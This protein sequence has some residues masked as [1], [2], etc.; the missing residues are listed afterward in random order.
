MLPSTTQSDKILNGISIPSTSSCN[1]CSIIHFKQKLLP[2][3]S[4]GR[5]SGTNELFLY[6]MW[7]LWRVTNVVYVGVRMSGYMPRR[8]VLR[9]TGRKHMQLFVA[10]LRDKVGPQLCHATLQQKV[11]VGSTLFFA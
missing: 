10:K 6:R 2:S 7:L 5:K 11:E 3:S 4:G 1:N 9:L 8:Y